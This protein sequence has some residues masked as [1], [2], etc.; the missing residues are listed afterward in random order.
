MSQHDFDQR[1]HRTLLVLSVPVLLSLIAEPLTGLVDTAFVS[2]LGDGPAAALGVGTTLLSGVF[3]IFNF[4]SVGTQSEVA[5]FAGAGQLDRAREQNALALT[6]AACFGLGMLVI[7][8]PLAPWLAE[9]MGA[10]GQTT[11]DA[12]V[13]FRV[14]LFAAP[15]VLLTATAFGSLRGLQ[16]M[17]VPMAIALLVNALNI[18]LDAVLI[19]G[20]GPIPGYGLAG[21]AWATL[22]AQW[23]GCACALAAAFQAL[24]RPTRISFQGAPQLLRIGGDMFV[25]TGLLTLFLVFATRAATRIGDEA[26]AAHHAIRQVWLFTALAL[27]ALAVSAQSLVG[28]YLGQGRVEGARRV[29]GVC[30]GWSFA[31]GLALTLAMLLGESTIAGL[32]VPSEAHAVFATAWLWGAWAQPF[33]A[34]CF[35]TDGLHWGTRDYRYLRNVMVLASAAGLLALRAIDPSAPGALESVWLVTGGWILVRASF[36]MLR[37]WPGLGASPFRA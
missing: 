8:W 11:D 2:D 26:G 25:R 3:W 12:V 18:V 5:R 24:G 15:A 10:R 13:Y 37:I 16:S 32:L 29:A 36:G 22:L 30:C 21:A 35:A 14:R 6:L 27:D 7:G 23:I 28:W 1:P 17:R 31:M 20:A 4:L 19:P 33:N 9:A 34:L